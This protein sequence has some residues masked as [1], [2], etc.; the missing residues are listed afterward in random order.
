MVLL[1]EMNFLVLPLFKT[2]AS[3]EIIGGLH[4]LYPPP[5]RDCHCAES[6][7]FSSDTPVH[8]TRKV[9]RMSCYNVGPQ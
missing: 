6:C 4:P 9:N 1:F 2:K 5:P 8:P 7:G 3:V